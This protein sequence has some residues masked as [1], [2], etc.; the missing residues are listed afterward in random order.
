M[1]KMTPL[2]NEVSII[3]KLR[4][5]TYQWFAH[6]FSQELTHDEIKLYQEGA[7]NTLFAYFEE[8][9]LT[10][11]VAR[12][13]QAI[14]MLKTIPDAALELKG[15]FAGCFLLEEENGAMPYASLHLGEDGMMYAEA[16]R[17]MREL[18]S[19]SGLQIL[20]SFKE[21]SDHLAIYL[22]LM[23]KWCEQLSREVLKAEEPKNYVSDEYRAQRSFVSN[24]ILAW[25]PAWNERLSRVANCRSEFYQALGALLLGFIMADEDYLNSELERLL[26]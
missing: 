13:K 11:E 5:E 26:I 22:A 16:E 8:I 25:L 9:G 10:H 20:E 7:L 21:P 18:L 15:D 1:T 6:L 4:A 3:A 17:K 19:K 12:C 2:S 14:E 24:G 23:Q